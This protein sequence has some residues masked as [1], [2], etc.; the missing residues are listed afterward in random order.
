MLKKKSEPLPETLR[1]ITAVLGG[2]PFH[3]SSMGPVNQIK[4]T[5]EKSVLK[6]KNSASPQTPVS[7]RTSVELS[8]TSE[9][10]SVTPL[11]DAVM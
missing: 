5:Q 4:H 7:P 2:P 11:N 6:N 10:S 3:F 9:E 1:Y 8:R